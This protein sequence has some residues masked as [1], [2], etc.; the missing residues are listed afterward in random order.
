MRSTVQDAR[1]IR[2]RQALSLLLDG[3][4]AASDVLAVASHMSGC[5]CCRRFAMQV[6]AITA[7]LRSVRHSSKT[8]EQ[9]IDYSRGART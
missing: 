1:C 3:E 8:T 2:M 7:E 5:G 4:A 9:T 6:V